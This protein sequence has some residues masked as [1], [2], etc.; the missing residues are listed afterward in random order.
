MRSTA[1]KHVFLLL[2]GALSLPVSV[3]PAGAA[4]IRI[5]SGGATQE[6]LRAITPDFEKASGD[7]V[8]FTFALVT[9]I[10]EKLASGEQADLI[11]LPVPLIAATEKTLGLRSEGRLVLARVGIGVI[12]REGATRRDISTRDAIRTLLLDVRSVAFP[13][14]TT[15][16]GA[17]LA[18][19]I[20]ELGIA[21]EVQPKLFVKAA[22]D[23]GAELV[24]KGAAEVGMYL[25][26]EV[27]AA[28]GISMVGLLPAAVQSYVVYGTAIP[29]YN[30]TPDS[31]LAFVKFISDPMRA[32][33]WKAAGFE[34]LANGN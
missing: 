21:D 5:L 9:A 2:I 28:K 33:R 27:Q 31:S 14:P 17:H 19:M 4:D 7:H 24:A 12:E 1:M 18:R 34:L 6:V 20:A 32:E 26:S 15:P 8:R 16:S 23:G 25:V 13:E 29:A 30:A 10:Q 11:L 22:I 3:S